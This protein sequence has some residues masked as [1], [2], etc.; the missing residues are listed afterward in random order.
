MLKRCSW[1]SLTCGSVLA[2]VTP[3]HAE[4]THTHTADPGGL[5]PHS[6][7]TATCVAAIVSRHWNTALSLFGFFASKRPSRTHTKETVGETSIQSLRREGLR[8]RK[9]GQMCEPS[10][11]EDDVTSPAGCERYLREMALASELCLLTEGVRCSGP[12]HNNRLLSKGGR[13]QQGRHST[14]FTDYHCMINSHLNKLCLQIKLS[15][16]DSNMQHFHFS[17]DASILRL[18]YCE[19][20]FCAVPS[21][22]P[23]PTPHCFPG[24]FKTRLQDPSTPPS[25]SQPHHSPL[26]SLFLSFLCHFPAR[27]TSRL[28]KPFTTLH[29]HHY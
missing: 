8:E 16:D 2:D 28:K 18:H 25:Q 13:S 3:L 19:L 10:P 5:A 14:S 23:P 11:P 24:L 22:P 1:T 6:E 17:S 26:L 4:S 27:Q 21:T 7:P 12:T 29:H 20:L 9:V 15:S